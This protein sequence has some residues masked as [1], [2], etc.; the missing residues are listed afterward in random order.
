MK[1]AAALMITATLFAFT[2]DFGGEHYEVFIGSDRV[3]S[4]FVTSKGYETPKVALPAQTEGQL[5]VK[6]NHC[7]RNGEH[8]SLSLTDSRNKVLKTWTYKDATLTK[9]EPM[10]IDLKALALYAKGSPI[11]LVYTSKEL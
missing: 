1:G 5:T 8:R 2:G 4:Q 6:Y 10:A 11:N 3:V 9:I 7:G